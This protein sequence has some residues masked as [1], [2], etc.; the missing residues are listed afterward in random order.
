MR[1]LFLCRAL[2]T[3]F[4]GAWEVSNASASTLLSKHCL[5]HASFLCYFTPCIDRTHFTSL[6]RSC[7]R[8]AREQIL[9]FGRFRPFTHRGSYLLSLCC[10]A[11]GTQNFLEANDTV[12]YVTFGSRVVPPP[13]LVRTVAEGLMEGGWAV[14][15]SL[16]EADASH[17]PPGKRLHAQAGRKLWQHTVCS[18]N[19]KIEKQPWPGVAYN[20]LSHLCF[21]TIYTCYRS[22]NEWFRFKIYTYLLNLGKKDE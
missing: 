17:L 15:W 13:T 5:L 12:V 18:T 21:T 1:C 19:Q 14:V 20:V 11:I 7:A 22:I 4:W 8:I 3:K 16:K 2:R 10:R 9:N 6:R